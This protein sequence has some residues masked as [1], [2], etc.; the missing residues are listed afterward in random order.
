M[1]DTDEPQSATDEQGSGVVSDD[2]EM[3]PLG[4]TVNLISDSDLE[5]SEAGIADYAMF[6]RID[7]SNPLFHSMA[8]PQFNDFSKIRFWALD[9]SVE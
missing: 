3:I 4:A 9:R 6:G 7:F 8:D 1:R 2:G 5:F